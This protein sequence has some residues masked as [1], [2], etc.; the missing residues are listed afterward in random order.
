VPAGDTGAV[1]FNVDGSLVTCGTRPLDPHGKASC[2]VTYNSPGT[3]SITA[4]YPGNSD[5]HGSSGSVTQT[6]NQ[7]DTT[8]AV[9]SSANPSTVGQSVT[10][11][12]TVSA[13][14]PGAGTPTGTVTFSEGST[15]LATQTLDPSGVATFSTS[16]LPVGSHSITATYG[17]DGNFNT[18]TGSVTQT[19]EKITTTTTIV[20]SANPSII[21]APVS[22]TATV[23]PVPDGG[24]VGFSDGT[25][26][27]SGCGSVTVSS[28]G[29][30]TCQVTYTGVG[31]HAI[32][33]AYSGDAT[34]AAS[35][36]TALTQRVAYKVQLQYS[37][38]KAST[39]GSTVPVKI[40]LLNAAGTN[41]SAA[42][43]TVTVTGLTPSPTPGKA[44]TGTF[45][46][47]TLDQGPGYQLNVKTVGY[48]KG[49][50]TL[51]FIASGDPTTHTAQ[52]VIG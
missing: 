34:Y 2:Q 49:T 48:P 42:G 4:T 28:N 47:M 8:T 15:T 6:V 18:S 35:T 23:S 51:S 7:A 38:T 10:F 3:H 19:V 52:V 37:Q 43:I 30:A 24:T 9:T 32:T 12:A 46:F 45:T 31:S 22:Y 39:S 13:S 36:S 27:I 16:A 17:G 21:G 50:Y 14:S 25:T 41:L 29:K 11:T 40:Q 26:P 1:I 44:P 33:A 5:Y 20:S